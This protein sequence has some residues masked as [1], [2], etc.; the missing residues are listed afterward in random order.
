MQRQEAKQPSETQRWKPRAEEDRAGHMTGPDHLH[1]RPL[2]TGISSGMG[3]C[4]RRPSEHQART[5][6]TRMG[7][8]AFYFH[9]RQATR[10]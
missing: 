6:A 5:F 3:R 4:P 8:E 10:S 7:D 9:S 2:A 1:P